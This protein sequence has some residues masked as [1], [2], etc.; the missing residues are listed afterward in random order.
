[1]EER[2]SLQDCDFIPS[3]IYQSGV[4]GSYGGSNFSLRTF[5]PVF[6][7]AVPT[8]IPFPMM[9]LA[10]PSPVF[11]L[12][13][14]KHLET[15]VS[16]IVSLFLKPRV[17]EWET[18]REVIVWPCVGW[19]LKQVYWAGPPW[20]VAGS[21]PGE[22]MGQP[23]EPSLWGRA[24]G[25]LWRRRIQMFS[26]RHTL[27]TTKGKNVVCVQGLRKPREKENIYFWN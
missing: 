19:C 6:I 8:G 15:H 7:M 14:S 1:M 25:G 24:L 22:S 20:L 16:W 13:G 9:F 23:E 5:I 3:Y 4:S 17:K 12:S 2:V 10:H 27:N 21:K 26:Q 11:S 18:E